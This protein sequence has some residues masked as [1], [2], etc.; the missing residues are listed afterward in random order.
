MASAPAGAA[1]S[2]VPTASSV[3]VVGLVGLVA[4]RAA[5]PV[6]PHRRS[7]PAAGSATE[8][9]R[10]RAEQARSERPRPERPT[11]PPSAERAECRLD[12]G[13][14]IAGLRVVAIGVLGAV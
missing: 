7:S 11:R 12:C 3:L 4:E 10:P 14:G 6:V 8:G 1:V 2:A 5:M 9:S 13:D